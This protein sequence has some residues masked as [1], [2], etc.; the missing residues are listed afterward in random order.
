MKSA[1]IP[2]LFALFLSSCGKPPREIVPT[3]DVTAFGARPD[4]GIDDTGAFLAAVRKLQSGE[5]RRL[6]IPRGKYHLREGG[7]PENPNILLF[8]KNLEGVEIEGEEAELEVSGFTAL[9]Y[10][11]GC[12]GVS[13]KGLSIDSPRPAFSV[14]EVTAS[15][16]RFFDLL[17][18]PEYPV[19]GKE[20]IRAFMDYDPK[21][22][23]PLGRDLDVYKA[24]ERTELIAPQTLRVWLNRDL[25]VP[26]GKLLVARHRIYESHA[27]MFSRCSE[28]ALRDCA[29]YSAPGMGLAALQCEN[30]SLKRFQVLK[31]PGSRRPMSVTADA[32]HF[33]GCKGTVTLEDCVFEGMGDDGVN[34]KSGLYLSVLERVDE[35]SVWTRHNLDL[36]SP[37]DPGETMEL[38]HVAELIPFASLTVDEVRVEGKRHWLRFREPL[39]ADLREGDVLGNASRAPALRMRRC[40]V[41]ENR[42]RGVLCQ[43]RDAVIE[44]CLFENCSS[45]GVLVFTEVSHF[46][47]SIGTRNVTVR[48]NIFRN[49]NFGAAAAEGSLCAMAYL[50][51]REQA[52]RPGVHKD[53]VMEG[54]RVEG[55]GE[56]GI[57]AA[58]V[59]GLTLRN[60]TI[61]GACAVG[62]F[63]SGRYAIRVQDCAR[64]VMEGNA[65]DPARQ[66][67]ACEGGVLVTPP[68]E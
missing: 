36:V 24:A 1:I 28:V 66:G 65:A 8:F 58:A 23:L 68:S 64:V 5:A 4:D 55:G 26:A 7:N 59:D 49:C 16:P 47:E 61:T 33:G 17:V 38:S 3:A 29:V 45:A 41:R 6:L 2:L 10:F 57:F 30:V 42:A 52:T 60:N 19:N 48:R 14:G 53:V 63:P 9:F 51:N 12:K 25:T 56:S 32:T 11:T 27:F 31:R 46:F 54:N 50:K 40:V 43:T 22:R 18:E 62:K 37:P 20:P 39:P 67:P 44:D 35:R 34:V 21:T 15:G 13:V